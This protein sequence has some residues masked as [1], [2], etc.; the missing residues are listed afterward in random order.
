VDIHTVITV[1]NGFG[2][3]IADFLHPVFNYS[4]YVFLFIAI[5]ASAAYYFIS[6][7][8][9]FFDKT[10]KKR[11]ED[12]D[13]DKAPFVTIQIPTKNETV[14]LRCA[15]HCLEF[16]YP[17]NK[18]EIIIGDDSTEKKISAAISKFARQHKQVKVTRR[19][20]NEGYKAGN[21]NYMLKHSKGELIVLFDSDFTPSEDF[22]RRI[23]APFQ[24]DKN[25]GA[26]QARWNFLNPNQN[27]T[28][29]LGSTIVSVFHHITLPFINSRRNITFLCGSAEAVRKDVLIKLGGWE[30]G[31]LTEDIEYSLRLL[32]NGYKIDY[33]AD[34][35]CYSEVPYKPKDLYKQQKRWA[36]GFVSAF[37]EHGKSIIT[38]EKLSAQDKAY[39]NFTWTGYLLSVLL[40][41]MF[42]TGFLS[43]I[44]HRPEAMD[45]PKFFYE[46]GR[47]ALLS[48]GI[49]FA[50]VIAQVKSKNARSLP[51]MF[52]SSFSYGL[53]VTYHVN[54]G[55]YKVLTGKPMP[56]FLLNKQGNGDM[57]QKN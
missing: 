19:G 33:L 20:T 55:L 27:L 7:Y 11:Y 30:S 36:Y 17:K 44:T 14:A 52:A 21:L 22:L 46:M 51:S 48:S 25:L 8:A 38:S 4:F 10:K 26:V 6:V 43:F 41:L 1:F 57:G 40:L 5:A 34:L 31:S 56:W 54:I 16:D 42:V 37:K 18:Y 47:N 12:L 49:I 13:E 24:Q 9:I 28:S 39:I 2:R 15:Q 3:G 32:K 23:V 45:I 50:S 53:V 35:E 29:V